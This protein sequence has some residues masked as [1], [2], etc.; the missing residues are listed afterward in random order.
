[1]D[2]NL[3][4]DIIPKPQTN[5]I[6]RLAVVKPSTSGPNPSLPSTK[7]NGVKRHLNDKNHVREN[8][9]EIEKLYKNILANPYKIL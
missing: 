7:V 2:D 9:I 3:F 6:T 4:S 1:V 5:G 8:L